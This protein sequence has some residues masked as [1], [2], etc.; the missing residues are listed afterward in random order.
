VSRDPD[1]RPPLPPEVIAHDKAWLDGYL[2]GKQD[3]SP[4]GMYAEALPVPA[5]DPKSVLPPVTPIAGLDIRGVYDLLSPEA[6]KELEAALQADARTRRAAAGAAATIPLGGSMTL[7]DDLRAAIGTTDSSEGLP[8]W[9]TVI[10][11]PDG[12]PRHNV[13]VERQAVLDAIDALALP[14]PA[15]DALRIE[16]AVCRS[17]IAGSGH[18]T[19][20]IPCEWH[21]AAGNVRVQRFIT[22][23]G[24]QEDVT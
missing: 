13:Y 18:A 14:V 5:L 8:H 20:D 16:E 10:D 1:D 6:R 19:G 9:H 21:T 24:S 11:T 7:R 22:A 23:L 4:G 12:Q 17:E 3:Y 15:L 2:H